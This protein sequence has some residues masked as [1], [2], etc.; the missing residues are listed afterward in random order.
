MCR[1]AA[2][3]KT[4]ELVWACM[5]GK[6]RR[7]AEC[8]QLGWVGESLAKGVCVLDEFDRLLDR[9]LRLLKRQ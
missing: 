7:R 4:R 5:S 1:D 6:Q 8:C 3:I 2:K 9:L